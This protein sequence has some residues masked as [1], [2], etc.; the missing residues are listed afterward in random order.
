MELP[1]FSI[2]DLENLSG[3]KAH[4]IRIWE[5]RYTFLKPRRT[6]TNIR[7]YC[8]RELKTVLNVSLLSK[9]GYKIS[10]INRMSEDE[11]ASKIV[12]LSDR[13][14]QQARLVND[15]IAD[16]IDFDIAHFEQLLDGYILVH[17]IDKAI[18]RIVFPFLD[19]IGILWLTNHVNPAQ[20]H[21]VSHLIRQKLIVGI[22]NAGTHKST[23]KTV[24]LFL[25]E[26]EY[27]ELGLL[28]VYYL[29]RSQGV[30]TLYLGAD[31]MLK[32]LEFVCQRRKPDYLY[33]HLTA[34]AGNFNF[35]RFLTRVSQQIG[36]PLVISGQL[37][38][39]RMRKTLPGVDFRRSIPEVL[40]F[41]ASL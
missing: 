40:G 21:L 22:E 13:E 32:D 31:L 6:E 38:R 4:T 23:D 35:E 2:K 16:M 10:H 20:E 14:A 11:L 41:I 17:G 8:N 9:Y 12:T 24:L 18:T 27:H 3:I 36:I 25:P 39:S 7:F 33:T 37:A 26:G 19:R 1:V 30:N 34:V 28:Y 29:L 15:L 5:Q